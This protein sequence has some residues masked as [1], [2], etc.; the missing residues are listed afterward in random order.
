M[1]LF[2]PQKRTGDFFEYCAPGPNSFGLQYILEG[3]RCAVE[4]A[5]NTKF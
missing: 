3:Y 5:N 2:G 1:V 4:T